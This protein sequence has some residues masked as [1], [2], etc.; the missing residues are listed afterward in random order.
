M[1]G[2]KTKPLPAKGFVAP[3]AGW[4]ALIMAAVWVVGTAWPAWAADLS[5]TQSDWSAGTYQ[6]AMGLDPEVHPGLLIP[7]NH[8]EDMRFLAEPT[9]Y[10]GIFATEVYHDSLFLGCG[11]SPL[12]P[13]GAEILAYDPLNEDFELQ[14]EPP[15]EGVLVLKARADTL[16]MPGPDTHAPPPGFSNVYLYGGAQWETMSTVPS[17]VHLFDIDRMDD[18]IYVSSGEGTGDASIY[19]SDDFCQTFTPIFTVYASPEHPVRRLHALAVHDGLL[20]MQ[21]DGWDP[22]D[23]MVFTFDGTD[24]DTIPVPWFPQGGPGEE[25]GWQGT[26][27]AWGDSLLLCIKNKFYIFDDGLEYRGSLPF[28]CARLGSGFGRYKDAVY[29]GA[30]TD[31]LHRWTPSGGWTSVC[32]LGLEP[33]TEQIEGVSTL[34]GRLYVATARRSGYTGGRLYVSACEV[35]GSLIS[36]PHDF[37]VA[38]RDGVL[39]WDQHQPNSEAFARFQ[40]RSAPSLDLLPA[41]PWLGP[42]GTPDTHYYDPGTPLPDV[43]NGDRFFQYRVEMGSPGGVEMPI[44]WSVTLE[45]DSVNTG[46]VS[47]EPASPAHGIRIQLAAPYPQPATG[48]VGLRA[49][50]SGS[51]TASWSGDLQLRILDLQGREVRRAWVPVR[52][53]GWAR[54]VWDLRSD[55]GARVSAGIYQVRIHAPGALSSSACAAARML[56]LPR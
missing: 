52:S 18:A 4:G 2:W 12:N 25:S 7:E 36:L 22:E 17:A 56:V 39:S 45:A 53:D 24:W 27:T 43:H 47:F 31:S 38:V 13:T 21:P 50:L 1:I 46:A 44:L 48:P 26:F 20:Y 34:Y 33:E 35:Y 9:D 54:W 16:Y 10:R 40:L 23:D 3:A 55:E 30:A 49:H 15:E 37:G 28:Y 8:P 32:R 51:E 14:L 6:Q 11:P 41:E 19:R 29:G 5:W 42:D